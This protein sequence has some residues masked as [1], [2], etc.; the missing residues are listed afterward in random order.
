[1]TLTRR[2][3]C[4][5]MSR[6]K[7]RLKKKSEGKSRGKIYCVVELSFAIARSP[8]GEDF[9]TFIL[10]SFPLRLQIWTHPHANNQK[11]V[12]IGRGI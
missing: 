8:V 1:M 11:A 4:L 6:L 10:F 7:T 9:P 2:K 3:A 12:H 5:K